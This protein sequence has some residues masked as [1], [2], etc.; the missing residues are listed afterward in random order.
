MQQSFNTGEI[1]PL[2]YGRVSEERY[3]SALA[4]CLN[5]IPTLQGPLLR[6]PGTKMMNAVKNS[7]AQPI[8]IPFTYSLTQAYVIELGAGYTRFYTNNGQV[9]SPTNYY[10]VLSN[11]GNF[12]R[13][14]QVPIQGE[15]IVTSTLVAGPAILELVNNYA[16]ADL[17]A[18][19]WAQDKDTLYIVHP[20]HPPTTLKLMTNS[21]YEWGAQPQQFIDGPYMPLNS[22]KTVADSAAVTL[23]PNGATGVALLTT[24]PSTAITAT[25][26]NGAGA[27]RIT[28]VGHGF[29]TGAKVYIS[30]IVGTTEA[31]NVVRGAGPDT[32][33]HQYWV[34]TVING[35]QFDLIG[36]AFVNA[37][38]SGGTV[39]PALFVY[40]IDTT[41]GFESTAQ[42][43]AIIKGTV[44]YYG[45]LFQANVVHQAVFVLDSVNIGGAPALPDLNPC[46]FW[47]RGTWTPRTI[48]NAGPHNAGS[49][50]ACVTFHQDRL[51]FS[52]CP[53]APQEIDGSQSGNYTNFSPSL[54]TTLVVSDKSAMQFTLLSRQANPIK[55]LA[56]A[57]QG[58]LAGGYDSEWSI[59]P[60]SQ[61]AALTPT[62]INAQQTSF[63]GSAAA[64]A[65]QLGNAT[66]YIQRA[67]R[68]LREINF[69]FQVGTFRS[70]DLTELAEHITLPSITKLAV[71]KETQPLIWALRSDGQLISMVYNRDDLTIKAGW[72]RHQ[73]GGRSDSGGTPPVVL[74]IAIIPDPTV[75][76]DQMWMLVK[77][78]I[79]GA[80]VINIEYLTKTFDDSMAQE[81][82]YQADCGATYD[83]PL[84]ITGISIATTAVVTSASH[85]LSNGQ[86]VK[87]TDVV[88]L[89]LSSTDIDGNVSI[90]NAVNNKTFVVAGVATNTFQ[91]NDFS[92]NPISTVGFSAWISG[93]KAR[94]LVTSITGLTWLENETI[95]VLT[96]GGQHPDVVVS[97]SGGITLNYP[98][99]KV[100]LGYAYN[101]DGQMMRLEAGAADGTSIGKTRRVTRVA[102][103]LH[104]I[105][106]LLMGTSFTNLLP[107]AFAQADQQQADNATPLFSGIARDGVESAYDFES[108]IC[109]R[110]NSL[111]PGMINSVT[112]FM[113]EFDI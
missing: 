28:A 89:N 57:P 30:G 110:Q 94:K 3:K 7:A 5:H 84:L 102:F 109:F 79:N 77:R 49:F 105:G 70:T 63:F 59:T 32:A 12:T 66:L 41:G 25:V 43:F 15:T 81:D 73:L 19:R 75:T 106:Q 34:I 82:A 11:L 56:S 24:G 83:S 74:D 22:W 65:V 44:R 72:A 23:T 111:L 95:Q 104:K 16:Q 112:A 33:T 78:W 55:W 47:Y 62:N 87:I 91:L 40:D 10:Q 46:P 42:T 8:L 97:N 54:F 92:G 93:G 101:S 71:Q 45:R 61:N 60:S 29:V 27:I 107:L 38:I 21:G 13:L 67:K 4:T 103:M 58:L 26:N 14:D 53:S 100:Q 2:L 69:F 68:K 80:S 37:W 6:R 98:A 35:S 1:S 86:S 108:Q 9:T 85:G 39:Y 113:E 64:E 17:S 50:P 88:G 99:A 48:P 20:S 90:S 96:D 36:S 31:N 51:W 52:G 18:L 76:F